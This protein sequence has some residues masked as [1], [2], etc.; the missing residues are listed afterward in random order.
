MWERGP[1]A[2]HK[3]PLAF[4]HKAA[5][6]QIENSQWALGKSSSPC[7]TLE[8]VEWLRSSCES[9]WHSAAFARDHEKMRPFKREGHRMLTVKQDRAKCI[10]VTRMVSSLRF[11]VA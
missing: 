8:G 11:L 10:G 1:S 5:V 7:L 9:V 4:P 6:L 3:Y 2:S